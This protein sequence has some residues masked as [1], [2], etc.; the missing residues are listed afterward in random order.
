MLGLEMTDKKLLHEANNT[1]D[2]FCSDFVPVCVHG[3]VANHGHSI[4]QGF[5]GS[6][7]KTFRLEGSDNLLHDFIVNVQPLSTGISLKSVFKCR[8]CQN[9]SHILVPS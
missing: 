7:H 9:R 3:V 5:L 8:A 4:Q 1:A 2:I 6:A